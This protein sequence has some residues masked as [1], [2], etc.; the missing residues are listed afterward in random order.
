MSH[1]VGG[2]GPPECKL[3]IV[4]GSPN[5]KDTD[6]NTP[7]AGPAG[8][9]VDEALSK[10][11]MRLYDTYRTFVVKYQAPLNDW[12]K[13]TMVGVNVDLEYDKLWE[14]EVKVFK[15]NV[16]L[17]VGQNAARYLTGN[18]Y[19][20]IQESRGSILSSRDGM[21]KVI[22]TFEPNQLFMGSDKG[23]LNFVYKKVIDA[24]IARAVEESR[25]REFNLPSRSHDIC[26]DSLHAYRFFKEYEK[27]GKPAVD[28]ESINSIPVSIAFAFTRH[29]S[30]TI[31]LLTKVGENQLTEMSYR[32]LAEC[33][34]EIQ[35]A[36]DLHAVIGQNFSY[37]EFKL[38]L[39]RFRVG[40]VI[41]DTLLKTHT[42][43]PE[44]PDKKLN[45]QSSLWTREPFYKDEGKENKFG[46]HF[47]VK[48]FFVYNG[49]D[50]C[51]TKEIDEEQEADLQGLAD[52]FK[53]PLVDFYYNYVMR[54]HKIYL[55]M[56]NV[57]FKV[58]EPRR[59][60]LHDEYHL[61]WDEVHAKIAEQLKQAFDT[62]EEF[63]FNVKS[64]PQVY[65]M[66]YKRMGFP[67]YKKDPTSEDKII[68]L[69][70]T[71][72]KGQRAKYA[73]ILRDILTERRIR[74]QLSRAIN[75][76]PDY[77]GRCKTA[78]KTSGTE[79]AR[80]STNTLK[81][82]LRPK[83]LGLAFHTIPKHG[84]FAKRV[85]SMF[86]PD[87][88]KIFIQADASQAEARIV[89]V[90]G[91]DWELLEAFDKVDIHRRTAGLFFGFTDRLILT[92]GTV[93][94]VDFLE[95]DGPER[96]TGKM[97]RHAGN[98]DMGKARAANEFNVNAQKYEIEMEISEWRASEYI[99]L[100][101]SASPRI[102]GVFHKAIQDAL[103]SQRALVNPFGRPRI[104][105]GRVDSDL[106]KEG[107]AYIPQS[108]VAD[109][110][111]GAMIRI[112]DELNGDGECYFVSEN[113]DAIVMQAPANNW[114]PYARLMQKHMMHPIDFGPYC[115]LKRNFILTIPSDI[116]ISIDKAG[117]ITNYGELYK[118]KVA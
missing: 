28:I 101:H 35:Q 83:K 15:P 69:L 80:T 41:S 63:D 4:C 27:L 12:D 22:P 45:V 107:Y 53:V 118:A 20:N 92:P 6:A 34:K 113:H 52:Y 5:H 48:R 97:F 85:R 87:E 36:F 9:I 33:W 114:E 44:L 111:Q 117:N 51:V 94:I 84:K 99:R 71:H 38:T 40:R 11:G 73:P 26:S 25:T 32:Q 90:L 10:A 95:K 49:K 68:A 19:L 18:L 109:L 42:I 76:V 102:R 54:K 16:I 103:R 14:H 61:K 3:M 59:K 98:Y 29:H 13:Y 31:P 66:L 77:D 37:D 105:N 46:K 96:F 78:Y 100:F 104:F 93:N 8:Q 79:T 21:Y 64:Y 50:A 43:F 56:Q 82:P 86:V 57:G 72:C 1:Y 108:T 65:E 112:N 88:G 47:N 17:A 62:D 89:A 58:D 116:E 106:D 67:V 23:G 110:T 75:F 30:L 7:L 60:E 70:N 81:P 91:E 74:D 2:V 115:T 55:K 39:A 24:D